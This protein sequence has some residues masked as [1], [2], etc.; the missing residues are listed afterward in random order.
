M[1]STGER[2]KEWNGLKEERL[3]SLDGTR[4]VGSERQ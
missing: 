2:S 3:A 4:Q 1:T